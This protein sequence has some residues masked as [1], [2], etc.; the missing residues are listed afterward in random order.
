MVR[1]STPTNMISTPPQSTAISGGAVEI[2]IA[3][4]YKKEIYVNNTQ[5]ESP[6]LTSSL[7]VSRANLLAL[8]ECV[9]EWKTPEALSFLMWL[10][11]SPTKDPDIFCSKT[12]KDYL[13]MTTE[14]LSKSCLGFLPLSG[15]ELN[16]K[17][18]IRRAGYRKIERGY[19]L[20]DIL[21][22][23]VDTKYFLSEKMMAYLERMAEKCSPA[24][25]QVIGRGRVSNGQE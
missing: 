13:V 24:L 3:P 20:S 15:T 23:N 6:I 18:L 11:F 2:S 9:E 17:F 10:G 5:I 14:K 8:L 21:E 1:V 19:S 22:G 16:G 4:S 7:P 12:S 25:R